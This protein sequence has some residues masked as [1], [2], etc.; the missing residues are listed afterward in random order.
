[1]PTTTSRAA[2]AKKTAA[3]APRKAAARAR[4][5]R[6]SRAAVA[7]PRSDDYDIPNSDDDDDTVGEEP[8]RR[9]RARAIV[10]VAPLPVGGGW[11]ALS[12]DVV[13]ACAASCHTDVQ[14]MLVDVQRETRCALAADAESPTPRLTDDERRLLPM[15]TSLIAWRAHALL[16]A[17]RCELYRRI[18]LD[19]TLERVEC[20]RYLAELADGGAAMSEIAAEGESG[21]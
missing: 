10:P 20:E 9:R 21:K 16:L 13:A 3:A 17:D 15:V 19:Q 2:A 12:D 11:H 1:M 7:P 5:P 8:P 6:R 4:A 18:V 14:Q